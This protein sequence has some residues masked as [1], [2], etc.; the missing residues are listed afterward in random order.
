M[1]SDEAASLYPRCVADADNTLG[2]IRGDTE[3]EHPS[4]IMHLGV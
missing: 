2:G 4:V 1:A 3:P